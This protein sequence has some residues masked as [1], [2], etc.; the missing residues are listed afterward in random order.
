M[1][2]QCVSFKVYFKTSQVLNA[3]EI[4]RNLEWVCAALVIP[5]T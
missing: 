5:L 4:G 1:S 2:L 3:L